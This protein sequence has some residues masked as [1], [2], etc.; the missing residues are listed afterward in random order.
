MKA[1]GSRQNRCCFLGRKH[2]NSSQSPVSSAVHQTVCLLSW[3]SKCR[4]RVWV[5][6]WH[7]Q[8]YK[9]HSMSQSSNCVA[10]IIQ[11]WPDPIAASS[12]SNQV[13]SLSASSFN[14]PSWMFQFHCLYH[15]D[16]G[17]LGH[18]AVCGPHIPPS[19]K[20]LHISTKQQVFLWS[21]SS[22]LNSSHYDKQQRKETWGT[23]Q[24]QWLLIHLFNSQQ[25]WRLAGKSLPWI[26]RAA[27]TAMSS[28][29]WTDHWDARLR[30]TPA[31][32]CWKTLTELRHCW[33]KGKC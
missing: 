4:A 6:K 3:Y 9:C 12:E 15:F 11:L 21:G 7:L 29:I 30:R 26:K 22:F 31:E 27:M 14:L 25:P 2:P 33:S 28:P 24:L 13:R 19:R 17:K 1:P 23:I 18:L 5:R 16:A 32:A 20:Q 8:K 10:T